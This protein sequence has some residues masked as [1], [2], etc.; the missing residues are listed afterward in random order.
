MIYGLGKYVIFLSRISQKSVI[1]PIYIINWE[2]FSCYKAS[3]TRG[4]GD[5]GEGEKTEVSFPG[6]IMAPGFEQK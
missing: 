6:A 5:R 1:A 4:N 2:N 3:C